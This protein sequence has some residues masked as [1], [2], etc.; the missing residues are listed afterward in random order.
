MGRTREC[1]LDESWLTRAYG[2][3][4]TCIHHTKLINRYADV[5]IYVY[6]Y[7]DLHIYECVCI[8]I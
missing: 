8:N 5:C 7:I 3:S 4:H 2:M 6:I 1:V